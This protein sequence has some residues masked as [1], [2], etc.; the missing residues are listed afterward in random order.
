MAKKKIK[1]QKESSEVRFLK[2]LLKYNDRNI[3]NDG[4]ELDAVFLGQSKNIR[5]RLEEAK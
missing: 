2:I 3:K 1:K 4:T 5:K